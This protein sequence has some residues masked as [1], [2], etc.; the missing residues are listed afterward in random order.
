MEVTVETGSRLHLGLIDFQ[1]ALGRVYGGCGVY[2]KKPK[3]VL[4]LRNSSELTVSGTKRQV[5]AR[6]AKQY[7]AK[8]GIDEGAEIT[9]VDE[10]PPHTGLGSGTQTALAV[11]S[12]LV[13]L[14]DISQDLYENA[15]LMGRGTISAVGTHL[16]KHGGFVLEG[17]R[18]KDSRQISPLL[19]RYDFPENWAF[20]VVIPEIEE[21]LSGA[22]EENALR[23]TIGDPGNAGKISQITLMQML[24]AL[25]EE[26]IGS[27]GDALY[28][29]DQITGNYYKKIQK[30]VYREET[31][32]TVVDY[33]M[34]NGAAG[35]GQSSWGPTVYGVAEKKVCE[36][37]AK[38]VKGFLV[39]AGV[40]A[41]V[42]CAQ[43][44]NTGAKIQ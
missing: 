34:E 32:K 23:Q 17:G 16:F 22:L 21:G 30:G 14:Y 25:V 19:A 8:H 6:Y 4:K 10:I 13:R 9:V 12:G 43:A 15:S 41:S 18:P 3:L 37:L 7:L 40:K 44:R 33:M 26:D 31:I 29:V 38:N 11:G 42:S 24:P 2:I 1:G 39:D 5:F 20:T 36:R 27:F 35:C 28:T